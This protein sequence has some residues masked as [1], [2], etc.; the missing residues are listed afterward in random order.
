M[1]CTTRCP[2]LKAVK[3]EVSMVEMARFTQIVLAVVDY[4]N[5]FPHDKGSNPHS[6]GKNLHTLHLH[7][8][9]VLWQVLY[10]C[11]MS[12]N[13]LKDLNS[14]LVRNI[15]LQHRLLP[16]GFLLLCRCSFLQ[17]LNCRGEKL[18][19]DIDLHG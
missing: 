7:N 19:S 16:K 11:P 13:E 15:S 6:L 1:H 18:F 5:G 8:K 14:P 2:P 12:D 9:G 10:V 17:P 3:P 4:V